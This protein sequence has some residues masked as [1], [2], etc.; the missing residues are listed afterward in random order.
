MRS[1]LRLW[2]AVAALWAALPTPAQAARFSA[3][4]GDALPQG[5]SLLH[6][7]FGWPGISG[8]FLYGATPKASLGARFAFNYGL[9]GLVS[10]VNLGLKFQGLVRL[11][12]VDTGRLTLGLEVAPGLAL[13]FPRFGVTTLGLT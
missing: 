1:H 13:Y 5:S 6:A 10:G 3:F 11:G 7:Q 9:E 12:L 4:G 2:L 8:A